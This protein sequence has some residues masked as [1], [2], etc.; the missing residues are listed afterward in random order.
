MTSE[1][2][3]LFKAAIRERW[4]C[5][6]MGSGD[7]ILWQCTQHDTIFIAPDGDVSKGTMC[8]P[9]LIEFNVYSTEE[10]HTDEIP[11]DL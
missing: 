3:D 2:I 6:H 4:S 1:E 10:E 5:I 7:D 8:P 9:C 11:F